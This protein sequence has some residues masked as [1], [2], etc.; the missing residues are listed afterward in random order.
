MP[1]VE[2]SLLDAMM[3][4]V[5]MILWPASREVAKSEKR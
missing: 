3:S 1:F 2:S 5:S 4:T